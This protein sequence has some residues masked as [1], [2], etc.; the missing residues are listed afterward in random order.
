MK[1]QHHIGW[2]MSNISLSHLAKAH[3]FRISFFHLQV[4]SLELGFGK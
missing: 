4:K 2:T 1:I 3:K